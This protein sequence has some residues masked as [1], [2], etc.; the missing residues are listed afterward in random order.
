MT[1]KDK[2]NIQLTQAVHNYKVVK[3]V[4][5]LWI[6]L[7]YSFL[8]SA[9]FI[10]ILDAKLNDWLFY[11]ALSLVLGLV[12]YLI[13]ELV[14]TERSKDI[15]QAKKTFDYYVEMLAKLEWETGKKS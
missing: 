5:F 4:W 13:N 6:W 15:N 3:R 2:L 9:L 1:E 12:F 11:I 10:T 7:G 8:I 14:W